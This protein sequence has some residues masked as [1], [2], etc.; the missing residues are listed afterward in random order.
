MVLVMNK[1]VIVLEAAPRATGHK[2]T[3]QLPPNMTA[4]CLAFPAVGNDVDRPHMAQ[5]VDMEVKR[6]HHEST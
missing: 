6:Q 4:L 5:T 1:D 3:Y 2:R